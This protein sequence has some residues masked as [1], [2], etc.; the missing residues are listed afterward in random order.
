MI[1][2][3][4]ELFENDVHCQR[5]ILLSSLMTILEKL[6][7]ENSELYMDACREAHNITYKYMLKKSV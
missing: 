3:I 5:L 4:R 1:S 2:N 6:G 7:E